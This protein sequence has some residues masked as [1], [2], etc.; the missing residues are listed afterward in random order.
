MFINFPKMF[1]KLKEIPKNCIKIHKNV[2]KIPQNDPK[3]RKKF[4]KIERNS[5]KLYKLP[6]M[7]I[8]FRK[9]YQF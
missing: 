3:N 6:K 5:K 9:M 4:L 2:Y 7:F 1:I 8:K